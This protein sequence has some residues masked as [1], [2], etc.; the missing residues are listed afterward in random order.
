MW[1]D[2]H[3][4]KGG[5]WLTIIER[6]KRNERLDVCWV[7]LM[8]T[9]VGE[10]FKNFNDNVCGAVVNVR[11]KGDKVSFLYFYAYIF[12]GTLLFQVALW[13]RDATKGNFSIC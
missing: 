1:E 2:S 10:Q 6:T 5:R 13:T 8:M 12:L 3:N 9:L 11:Q 4:I 7:E